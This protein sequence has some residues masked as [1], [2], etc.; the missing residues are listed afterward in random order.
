MSF[1]A[2]SKDDDSLYRCA[3][4]CSTIAGNVLEFLPRTRES[5]RI[6]VNLLSGKLAASGEEFPISVE[7]LADTVKCR[8]QHLLANWQCSFENLAWLMVHEALSNFFGRF[9]LANWD[10][11]PYIVHYV[12]ADAGLNLDELIERQS[13]FAAHPQVT[14]DAMCAT[15]GLLGFASQL[16]RFEQQCRPERLYLSG[17]ANL[18][19]TVEGLEGNGTYQG[20][21]IVWSPVEAISRAIRHV[22]MSIE[23]DD[24][25]WAAAC[26]SLASQRLAEIREASTGSPEPVALAAMREAA[27]VILQAPRF[28]ESYDE[29]LCKCY[30]NGTINDLS[31]VIGFFD[32]HHSIVPCTD[33]ARDAELIRRQ[34]RLDG[35]IAAART[36]TFGHGDL[37][38]AFG[39]EEAFRAAIAPR[40]LRSAEIYGALC[41]LRARSEPAMTTV[42]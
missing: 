34:L 26:P 28:R 24:P 12:P 10:C 39:G 4:R 36:D 25:A 9:V 20:V 33:A 13:Y 17:Y 42:K 8:D 1:R 18:P 7:F 19:N 37:A 16:W 40:I 3:R 41:M 32:R 22:W 2:K 30:F 27:D 15:S 11:E 21:S 23:R 31:A 5:Q 35:E 29:L 38:T 14:F 6:L